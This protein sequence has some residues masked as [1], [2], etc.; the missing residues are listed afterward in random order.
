MDVLDLFLHVIHEQVLAKRERRGEVGLAP[1][2]FRD[3]LHK[4]DEAV[5]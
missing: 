1:A 4:I 2:D 3:L 5:I